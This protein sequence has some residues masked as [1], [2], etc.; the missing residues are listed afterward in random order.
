LNVNIRTGL[1][2]TPMTVEVV[3][4]GASVEDGDNTGNGNANSGNVGGA[5]GGSDAETANSVSLW[6]AFTVGADAN[7]NAVWKF[8]GQGAFLELGAVG[9]GAFDVGVHTDSAEIKTGELFELLRRERGTFRGEG[10]VRLALRSD[11]ADEAA[12]LLVKGEDVEHGRNTEE[13]L[14]VEAL[15]QRNNALKDLPADDGESENRWLVRFQAMPKIPGLPSQTRP[16]FGI[17]VSQPLSGGEKVVR[18]LY[19]GNFS[20]R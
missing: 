1:V 2:T 7:L 6:R 3:P 9:R 10:G 5:T 11:E 15:I 12:T 14:V 13:L 19:G 18:F 17:E 16:M 4:R 20:F 8:D